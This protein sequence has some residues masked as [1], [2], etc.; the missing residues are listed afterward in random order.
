MIRGVSYAYPN[1][2]SATVTFDVPS[3]GPVVLSVVR[4]GATYTFTAT[5]NG[6]QT[7]QSLLT[8]PNA[9]A[10]ENWFQNAGQALF[11]DPN[12]TQVVQ[13]RAHVLSMN[14]IILTI[15]LFNMGGAPPANWWQEN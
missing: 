15:G 9:T 4:S 3:M 7:T 10:F 11:V 13:V 8:A 5:K 1:S 14:P 12:A 2:N 6:V